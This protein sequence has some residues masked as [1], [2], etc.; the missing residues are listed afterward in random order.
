MTNNMSRLAR[1]GLM[2]VAL[3]ISI[4]ACGTKQTGSPTPDGETADTSSSPVDTSSPEVEGTGPEQPRP[5]D[6]GTSVS[7]PD[8]PAGEDDYDDSQLQQCITV[9][10]LGRTKVPAGVSVQVKTVRI[11]PPGVFNLNGTRCGGVRGCT[12][13]FAFTAARESCSVSIKATAKNETDAYLRLTGRCVS[14]S[15]QQCDELLADDRSPIPLR[16]PQPDPDP[17][18]EEQPPAPEENPPTTG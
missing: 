11:T 6:K 14:K 1:L 17:T 8:L 7:F 15:A 2:A 3:T 9:K 12:E 13:S 18:T 5:P 16:Q 10:W 4:T